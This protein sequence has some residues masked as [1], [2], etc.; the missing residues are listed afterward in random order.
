MEDKLPSLTF[1][2]VTAK[3]LI[4]LLLETEIR[5]GQESYF[6]NNINSIKVEIFV[7]NFNKYLL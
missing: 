3:R 5:L 6:K 7:C 2:T 1:Q 4:E